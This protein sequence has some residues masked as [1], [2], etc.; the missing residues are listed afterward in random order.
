M[1]NDEH[2]YSVYMNNSFSIE[3]MRQLFK[4]CNIFHMQKHE[5]L[6]ASN[7]VLKNIYWLAEGMM[8][9]YVC[10]EKGKKQVLAYHYPNSIL[11]EI[12]AF[13][14]DE[15]YQ[16][17]EAMKRSI[18]YKCNVDMF[19]DR[20]LEMGLM[21]DY[22]R[23][24]VRKTQANTVQLSSIA[25]DDCEERIKKYYNNELTHQQLSELIGCTRVQVTRSLNKRKQ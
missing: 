21:R 11:G 15:T 2:A 17:C 16:E 13:S 10:N 18:L 6:Y 1:S 14:G 4:D 8:E 9:V 25:L 5:R 22:L 19:Y 3:V 20:V 23:L 24:L 7:E 12:N